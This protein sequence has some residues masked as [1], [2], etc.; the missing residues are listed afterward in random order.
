MEEKERR[1]G[2]RIWIRAFAVFMILM[3]LCTVI[4]KSI[5]VSGLPRVQTKQAERKYIEHIVEAEGLI[6]EGGEQAVS[7]LPGLRVEKIY[8]KRGQRVE[9]GDILFQIDVADLRDL[10]AEQETAIHELNYQ[11]ADLEFNQVLDDQNREINMLWAQEDYES[12][13]RRTAVEVER[14]QEACMEAQRAL[15]EH[16]AEGYPLTSEEDR[17]KAED[18]YKAWEA[19]LKS[20]Q[21][22]VAEQE[23]VVAELEEQLEQEGGRHTLGGEESSDGTEGRE[24]EAASDDEEESGDKTDS[25]DTE[26]NRAEAPPAD[27]EESGDKTDS[28]DTDE[29]ADRLAAARQELT[30]RKQAL[31][32]H[33]GN[34]VEKPDF[35]LEDS[36]YKVWQQETESLRKALTNAEY[37]REDAIAARN[38]ALQQESRDV[39]NSIVPDRLDSSVERL[40]L[41]LAAMQKELST[42][43]DLLKKEGNVTSVSE[44]TVTNVL[45]STGGRTTDTAALLLTEDET[46]CQ[47][48]MTITKEQ[49]KYINVGD[50]VNVT[51][52]NDGT[53]LALTVDYLTESEA[54]MG[55]Y[56]IYMELPQGVG[57]PGVVGSVSQSVQGELRDCCIPIEALYTEND[58]YCVYVVREREGILGTELYVE[59]LD[60][61]VLDKNERYAALEEGVLGSDDKIITYATDP[62]KRGDTVR[63]ME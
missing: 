42:Y 30:R 10:I 21:N 41:Q 9:A 40:R 14:A 7:T 16:L 25:E 8:A 37:A 33:Y 48:R 49:K 43:Y 61:K 4:S 39:A 17:K 3:W 38:S 26:G 36:G 34:A 29:T 22:A 31:E 47:F 58:R 46:P 54:G 28:E 53:K 13:D 59:R 1:K 18:N 15:E 51:L 2:Y 6:V 52:A 60:V 24:G 32:K 63:Y 44:G 62:V 5:Y 35:S 55:Y 23:R 27:E 56:D 57:Q 19:Q 11:I 12:A 50:S 20:L 45:I